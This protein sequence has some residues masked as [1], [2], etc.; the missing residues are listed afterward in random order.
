MSTRRYH[1]F[2]QCLRYGKYLVFALIDLTLLQSAVVPGGQSIYVTP[3]GLIRYTQA[4]SA[5]IDPGS[6]ICPFSYNKE[7]Q[8]VFGV[9]STT[10]FGAQGLMACPDEDD[11][12]QV[13]ASMK[14]ATV[15]SGDVSDCVGFLALTSDYNDGPAAWQYT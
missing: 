10:A 14:N 3:G 4:H 7:D 9:I 2:L 6:I 8:D 1:S 11:E 12:W 15:P 13:Y 5:H